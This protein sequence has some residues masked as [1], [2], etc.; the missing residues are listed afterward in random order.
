M[1]KMMAAL[2]AVLCLSACSLESAGPPEQDLPELTVKLDGEVETAVH[3]SYCWTEG[4][5]SACADASGNPFDYEP[6]SGMIS[7]PTG[8]KVE[9]LFSLPPQSSRVSVQLEDDLDSSVSS[10]PVR[11]PDAPGRYG[12]TVFAEWPQGDVSYFFIVEAE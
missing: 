6:F 4:G 11:I 1:G 9:L 3:G 7:A 8:T 12:Y 2:L 5:T 10:G